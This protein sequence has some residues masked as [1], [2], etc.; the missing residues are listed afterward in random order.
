MRCARC[1]GAR[2]SRWS[3]RSPSRSGLVPALPCSASPT[4][5]CCGALPYK[6]P[7][8]LVVITW[9]CGRETTSRCRSRTR[10]SPISAMAHAEPSRTWPRCGRRASSPPATTAR[11]S[12]S[13]SA[14]SRPTSFRSWGRGLRTDGIFR[15]LTASRS[16]QSKPLLT[17]PVRHWWRSRSSAM[18]TGSVAMVGATTSSAS[19]SRTVRGRKSW[20]CSRLASS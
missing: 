19:A 17:L 18:N 5:S 12:R 15:S 11:P 13:R 14:S 9:I 1:A 2:C 10:T 8:R 16:R 4:L 3:L 7:D 6:D 20:A